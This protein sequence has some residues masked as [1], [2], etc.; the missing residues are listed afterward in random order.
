MYAHL[1]EIVRFLNLDFHL[2]GRQLPERDSPYYGLRKLATGLLSLFILAVSH[3]RE[4]DDYYVLLIVFPFY[5]KYF[6][7]LRSLPLSS[8]LYGVWSTSANADTA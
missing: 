2:M 7:V 6:E 4:L 8:L 3:R 1:H 5:N